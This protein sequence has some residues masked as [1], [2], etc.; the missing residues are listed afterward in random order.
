L[1]TLADI[2]EQQR[3]LYIS[4]FQ[5]RAGG[6]ADDLAT[7]LQTEALYSLANAQAVRTGALNLPARGDICVNRDGQ[8]VEIAR[9]ESPRSLSFD[10]FQFV[11][12]DSLQVALHPFVWDD[13]R[14]CIPEPMQAIDWSLISRWFETQI[15]M[16]QSFGTA[17]NLLNLVHRMSTPREVPE[18]VR[19]EIDFGSADVAVFESLLSVLAN[20]GAGLAVI[21]QVQVPP[22]IG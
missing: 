14:V 8:V 20:A 3:S 18:G 7:L 15:G 19:F 9:I 21:G 10:P 5:R 13:C 1:L 16:H 6:F 11:W 22:E 4:E 12:I 17:S 2:L